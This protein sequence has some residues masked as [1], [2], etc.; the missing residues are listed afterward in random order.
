MRYYTKMKMEFN[1]FY[2]A[3]RR[4]R[5]EREKSTSN[6]SDSI[7]QLDVFEQIKSRKGS[8]MAPTLI[9]PMENHQTSLAGSIFLYEVC[10][11][12]YTKKV[13]HIRK[14]YT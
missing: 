7:W 12:V 4:F 11:F 6:L 13:S 2:C 3:A 10:C 9:N 5:P 14:G 1:R 8:K